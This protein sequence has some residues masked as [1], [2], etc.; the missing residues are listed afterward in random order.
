MTNS[1]ITT[2]PPRITKLLEDPLVKLIPQTIE[3]LRKQEESKYEGVIFFY[4]NKPYQLTKE[5][6][7]KSLAEINNVNAN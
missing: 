3:E 4:L 5:E 7:K 2:L 1:Q 6:L